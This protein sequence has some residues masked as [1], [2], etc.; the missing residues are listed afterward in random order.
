M[1]ENSACPADGAWSRLDALE[2]RAREALS[3]Q[4]APFASVFQETYEAGVIVPVL[5]A[6]GK[7]TLDVR[8]AA[9]FFK[10]LLNDLRAVW[11]LLGDGYTSQAASVV[12]SLWE[13]ALATMCLLMSDKNIEVF[14]K[15]DNGEIPWS[16]INMSKMVVASEGRA[17]GSKE[18]EDGWRALYASYVW[19]C[20]LKHPTFQ[21]VVHDTSAST[22]HSGDYVVMALPN[23]S[24]QDTP[25][26]AMVAMVAL[27]R[28]QESIGAFA[29]ALGCGDEYPADYGFADRFQ[30]A[31]ESLREALWVFHD[32]P[33]PVDIRQSWFTKK[34]PP[35][36]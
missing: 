29:A 32:S 21:S 7:A 10:R 2:S 30:R 22:L 5:R 6:S 33:P 11:L 26:K 9:L 4:L 24:E 25:L 20:Q 34:H 13:N 23:T 27:Q 18:H 14:L 1:T 36:S 12:S 16:P 17:A 28:T 31:R 3:A 15:H 35:T 8:P 19:L